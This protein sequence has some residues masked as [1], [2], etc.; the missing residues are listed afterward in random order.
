MA[1]TT[2]YHCGEDVGVLPSGSVAKANSE[3]LLLVFTFTI[4]IEAVIISHSI[5]L[6]VH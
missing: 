5:I 3:K 4:M 6:A 2:R 1:R